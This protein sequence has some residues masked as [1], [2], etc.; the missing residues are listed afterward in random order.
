M[1]ENL[2]EKFYQ[3]TLRTDRQNSYRN[4]VDF[5]MNNVDSEIKS[6][7]DFGCG[8]GWFLY[9][10]KK[11]YK[12]LNLVGI[13][14]NLNILNFVDE[15]IRDKIIHHDLTNEIDLKRK[16]DLCMSIEVLEHIE[17]KYANIALKNI[18]DHSKNLIV[19]SAAYPDQGGNGHINEQPYEYW[20]EKFNKYSFFQD[21]EKTKEF[22]N[23][24]KKRNANKWYWK[25]IS[26]L[27]R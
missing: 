20:E 7:S 24:L 2:T 26:I 23:F 18:I 11:N 12:I 5:I 8:C 15:T 6:I 16:F 9:Y 14:P 22:R 1:F 25:N 3:K 4:I 10:F 21:K 27:K 19:F 13:E 17:E